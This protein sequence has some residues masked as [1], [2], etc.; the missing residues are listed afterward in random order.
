M[1]VYVATAKSRKIIS[2]ARKAEKK[3]ETIN[4][5]SILAEADR[6]SAKTSDEQVRA[7]LKK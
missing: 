2:D 4:W 7:I 1:K 6:Y 5:E 3:G